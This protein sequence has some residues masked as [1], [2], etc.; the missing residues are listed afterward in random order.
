MLGLLAGL[1]ALPA[2]ASDLYR[3]KIESATLGEIGSYTDTITRSGDSIQIVSRLRVLVRLLGIVLHREEADR[4]EVWRDGRIVQFDS[5]TTANSDRLVVHGEAQGDRFVITS[6]SGTVAA[7]ADIKLSNPWMAA[8]GGS[9]ELMSTKTGKLE[10]V[11]ETRADDV[12]IE[13]RGRPVPTRHYVFMTNKRQEVWKD[14][15]GVPVRFL[16]TEQSGPID[17]VL[18]D[19]TTV[20]DPGGTAARNIPAH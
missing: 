2:G 14:A 3:Y 4:V 6:P 11:H 8:D 13:V 5:I 20:P 18:V 19:E 15:R 10:A 1:A 7:A 12:V 16:S 9:A 17:F